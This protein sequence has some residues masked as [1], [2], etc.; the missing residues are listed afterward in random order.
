LDK[1]NKLK[2]SRRLTKEGGI[3]CMEKRK[4]EEEESVKKIG[5]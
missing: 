2:G 1:G 4:K 5:C 3:G